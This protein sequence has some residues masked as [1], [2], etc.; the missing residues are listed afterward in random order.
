VDRLAHNIDDRMKD[1]R[2][3]SR[4]SVMVQRAFRRHRYDAVVGRALR[5]TCKADAFGR[6]PVVVDI[7]DL[8]SERYRSRLSV[9]ALPRW[10]KVVLQ[11]HLLGLERGLANVLKRCTHL[12]LANNLDIRL[13]KHPSVSIL[14]NIPFHT[15]IE[16]PRGVDTQLLVT[17]GHW[18]WQPNIDGVDH[19]LRVCWP[20]IRRTCPAARYKIIGGGMSD[21]LRRTWGRVDGVETI[22]FVDDLTD[23]YASA[24]LVIAPIYHG[25]G[26]NIKVLEA[27]AYRRAVVCTTHAQRGYEHVLKDAD[28]LC[29]AEDDRALAT[30]CVTLLTDINRRDT[31]AE[32]GHALV[33]KHFSFDAFASEVRQTMEQILDRRRVSEYAAGFAGDHDELARFHAHLETH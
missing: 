17:V 22:G 19:F 10:K 4:V 7:D 1:Y 14:Q 5:Q 13:V 28:A 29:V 21:A 15:P 26:T 3:D 23:A 32:R 9:P 33:L 27:L 18:G 6:V 31:M 24:A 12:W 2:P 16:P 8:D 30:A 11:R 20:R 25:G